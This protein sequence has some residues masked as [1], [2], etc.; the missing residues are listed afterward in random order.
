MHCHKA[1]PEFVQSSVTSDIPYAM[2]NGELVDS[3]I[4]SGPDALFNVTHFPFICRRERAGNSEV[5]ETVLNAPA[6]KEQI[7]KLS[8]SSNK[9]DP[10]DANFETTV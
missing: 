10:L 8:K 4:L 9:S 2:V 5:T 6:T 7:D 1:L 3:S